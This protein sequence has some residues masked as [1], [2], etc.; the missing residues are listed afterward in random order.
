[1]QVWRGPTLKFEFDFLQGGAGEAERVGGMAEPG[2]PA[3]L[4]PGRGGHA[5]VPA[6]AATDRP[7][8]AL[9]LA[10]HHPRALR[11][12]E[13]GPLL[14]SYIFNP[15]QVCAL[16]PLEC[17]VR[18]FTGQK[19]RGLLAWSLSPTSAL[20]RLEPLPRPMVVVPLLL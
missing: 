19:Q 11:P 3:W 1:M 14:C 4:A 13:Q 18:P 16:M 15:S 17:N 20:A 5:A 6:R 2:E 10:P 12:G 9:P 8:E 7:Q